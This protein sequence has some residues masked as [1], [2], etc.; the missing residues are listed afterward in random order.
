MSQLFAVKTTVHSNYERPLRRGNI[1]SGKL[2][3]RKRGATG[4]VLPNK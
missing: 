4:A 3:L 2:V 1:A